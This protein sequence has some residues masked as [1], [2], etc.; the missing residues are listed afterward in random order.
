MNWGAKESIF[1]IRNEKGISFKDHISVKEFEL[2]DQKSIASLK[3][4]NLEKHFSIHFEE[5]EGFS[6]VYAFEQ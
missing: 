2:N 5:F 1:K 3:I 4:E 6:L